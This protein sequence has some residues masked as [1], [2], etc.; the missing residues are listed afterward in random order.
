M[1]EKKNKLMDETVRRIAVEA[2]PL[3]PWLL[4]GVLL[5]IVSVSAAVAAP[6]LMGRLVQKL[7]DFG[8]TDRTGSVLSE[9]GTG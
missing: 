6:E 1:E 7:Y 9:L 8:L 4:L 3:L 2:K 5:D